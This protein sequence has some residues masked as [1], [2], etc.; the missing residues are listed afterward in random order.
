MRALVA[1]MIMVLMATS[2]AL[3]AHRNIIPSARRP[4]VSWRLSPI[5]GALNAI[6]TT[7][8]LTERSGAFAVDVRRPRQEAPF[9]RLHSDDER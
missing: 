1:I 2:S 4:V 7:S 3:R 5:R 9:V 8:H 6:R